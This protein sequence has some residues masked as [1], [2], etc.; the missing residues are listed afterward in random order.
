MA[1][2]QTKRRNGRGLCQFNIVAGD[3]AKRQRL[4]CA[5]LAVAEPRP[6]NCA[7]EDAAAAGQRRRGVAYDY[8]TSADYVTTV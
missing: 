8:D 5:I 7:D 1:G 6:L 4:M 3:I 2:R